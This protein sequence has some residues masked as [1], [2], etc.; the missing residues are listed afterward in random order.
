MR[1]SIVDGFPKS[2]P[3]YIVL[4]ARLQR[5]KGKNPSATFPWLQNP[6]R[7]LEIAKQLA[8]FPKNGVYLRGADLAWYACGGCG[9]S[10][11]KLWREYQTF[12]E[13]QS[14]RCAICASKEQKKN[15]QMIDNDGF[16]V[17]EHGRRTDVIG[18]RI[19]AIP[20][21]ECDTYWSY[22][23]V[24][25]PGVEWW[26]KLP[27]H[28]TQRTITL[29]VPVRTFKRSGPQSIM[30]S[31][32]DQI[33]LNIGETYVLGTV[34]VMCFDHRDH[35]VAEVLSRMSGAPLGF[36]VLMDEVEFIAK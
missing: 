30:L 9:A 24:P 5:S 11:C 20:T 4:H 22:T 6:A 25:G 13:N 7:A 33:W 19:P 15:I 1:N 34:K 17:N 3:E 31:K 8:Y 36:F 28:P 23:S 27:T 14:L 26:R 21:E 29:S 12:M 35:N 16:R 18:D 10:N 2:S 32:H